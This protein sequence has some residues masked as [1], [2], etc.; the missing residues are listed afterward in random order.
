[1]RR[2]HTVI[3]FRDGSTRRAKGVHECVDRAG[4]Q[5]G[6]PIASDVTPLAWPRPEGDTPP[7]P[8]HPVPA[9]SLGRHLWPPN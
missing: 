7:R 5:P 6:E 9:R 4:I 8:T 3:F 2:V 1:M